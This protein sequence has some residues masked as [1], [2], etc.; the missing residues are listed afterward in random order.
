VRPDHLRLL[1]KGSNVRRRGATR[2]PNRRA[3]ET[4]AR[5]SFAIAR[6]ARIDRP[7]IVARTVTLA[8]LVTLLSRFEVLGDKHHGQCWSPTRYADGSRSRGNAGVEAVS[9]LVFDMDRVPPDEKRLAGVYW[10]AHTT[11]SHTAKAPRWRVILPLSAPVA[12]ADWRETWRRGRAALC[13][14]ADPVCKDA[15]RAYWLPS[16]PSGGEPQTTRHDG[17][18]LEVA[19]LP[20]LP[21]ERRPAPRRRIAGTGR[22]Q[23]YL[24]RVAD[25]LSGVAS[26]ERNAALNRAAW[27]L[28]HW[29]A[30]GALDQGEVEDVLYAAA[31]HNGLV[32]DDG[33]R[34]CWATIRSG[35]AAGLRQPI[36][37]ER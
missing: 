30:A 22:S 18:L 19:T 36:D 35:L 4:V 21:V 23:T 34:Q 15:S 8:Q 11:W 25:N 37:L 16:H 24:R 3:A 1:D 6:F 17:P 12:A 13:P 32:A 27:T 20:P 14:E 5:A 9:C 33:Q 10:L 26:G 7:R 28:G 2:G 31:E 29:V